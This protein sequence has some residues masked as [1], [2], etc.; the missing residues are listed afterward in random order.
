MVAAS[1]LIFSR[2]MLLLRRG[3]LGDDLVLDLVV[4]AL[5]Q[6]TAGDELVFSGV[7]AVVDDALGVGVADAGDGLE[8]VGRGGV[9]VD[10]VGG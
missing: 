3:L 5:R 8:L 10:F 7:G 9:D 6:N 2:D 1:P 4:D